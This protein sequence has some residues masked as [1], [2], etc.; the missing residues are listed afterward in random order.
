MDD[1]EESEEDYGSANSSSSGDF[2]SQEDRG[3]QLFVEMMSDQD[4]EFGEEELD[5]ES[6]SWDFEEI[7]EAEAEMTELLNSQSLENP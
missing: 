7:E 5:E 1:D 4:E 2:P 6:D 3:P